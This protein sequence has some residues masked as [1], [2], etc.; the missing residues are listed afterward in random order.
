MRFMEFV[1][2]L[3][4][5]ISALIQNTAGAILGVVVIV[6]EKIEERNGSHEN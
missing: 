5:C 2:W 3:I 1:G 4:L 6:D